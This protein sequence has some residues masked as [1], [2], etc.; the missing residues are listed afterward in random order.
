MAGG[1]S[2][3]LAG[4][5]TVKEILRVVNAKRLSA[6]IGRRLSATVDSTSPA[7]AASAAAAAAAAAAGSTAPAAA[8]TNVGTGATA[9]V[10]QESRGKVRGVGSIGGP[11]GYNA[12][13]PLLGSR[14][15]FEKTAVGAGGAG[16]VEAAAELLARVRGQL[17]R[18]EE[19][20]KG[21]PTGAGATLDLAPP[22]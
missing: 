14:H 18:S 19:R 15:P 1:P 9:M 12:T 8:V 11:A 4:T 10:G 7:A 5:R 22:R 17:A 21:V 20:T 6:E 16:K 13:T 3:D 2:I